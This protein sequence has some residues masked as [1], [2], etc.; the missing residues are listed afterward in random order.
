MSTPQITV[1]TVAT[2]AGQN[3][4]R[5]FAISFSRKTPHFRRWHINKRDER[6]AH[7]Y[8]S[9]QNARYMQKVLD[10]W[11]FAPRISSRENNEMER[12]VQFPPKGY[13]VLAYPLKAFE[14]RAATE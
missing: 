2:V 13:G 8:A 1:A 12:F 6:F 11:A 9:K 5:Y 10:K 7:P 4:G 14:E 3:L